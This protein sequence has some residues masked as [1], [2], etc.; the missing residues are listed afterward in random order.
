[1]TF[2]LLLELDGSAIGVVRRGFGRVSWWGAALEVAVR[3][4]SAGV[5]G[6]ARFA[7]LRC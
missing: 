2:P 3:L 6:V 7:V 1:M 5:L 4:R